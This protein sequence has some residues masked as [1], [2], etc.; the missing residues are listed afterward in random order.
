MY[1]SYQLEMVNNSFV[2]WK[3]FKIKSRSCFKQTVSKSCE[4]VCYSKHGRKHRINLT[5]SAHLH[6]SLITVWS[7]HFEDPLWYS[8]EQAYDLLFSSSM[9][10]STLILIFSFHD[11]ISKCSFCIRDSGKY[12]L[13]SLT[14]ISNRQVARMLALYKQI[15]S[16]IIKEQAFHVEWY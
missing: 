13:W 11:Y 7:E 14:H 8:P 6:G 12:T 16:F 9:K 2:R 1:P 4:I 10:H 15:R 5:F 3:N